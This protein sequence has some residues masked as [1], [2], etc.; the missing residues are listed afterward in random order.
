[1]RAEAAVTVVDGSTIQLCRRLDVSVWDVA[2]VLLAWA[3]GPRS[4]C[5]PA[6]TVH[7]LSIEFV[8]DRTPSVCPMCRYL[9]VVPS[10]TTSL[11]CHN[12]RVP[13][14]LRPA[15]CVG[16]ATHPVNGSQLALTLTI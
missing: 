5:E 9:I 16:H 1:L 6:A 7:S 2:A 3:T 15:D 13:N 14:G 12:A 8:D 11:M 4:Q 10:S